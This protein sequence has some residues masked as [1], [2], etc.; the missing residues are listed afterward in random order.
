MGS[1]DSRE[2]FS[3][4]FFLKNLHPWCLF[5]QTKNIRLQSLPQ[6]I[7]NVFTQLSNI[8]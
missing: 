6:A 4:L 8:Q 5:F 7:T 3:S 1:C 2:L